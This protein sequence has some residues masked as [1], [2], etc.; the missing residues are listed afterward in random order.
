L[1][2][3]IGKLTALAAEKRA[4]TGR[5]SD[6]GGL[7]LNVSSA[8]TKSWIF[9]WAK[10]GKRREMGLGAYPAVT[11]KFAREKAAR[12]RSLVAAGIDPITERNRRQ[13]KTFAECVDL[14]IEAMEP[15]W[16]N[17]KHRYQWRQTLTNY[18][19]AIRS[20]PVASITTQEVLEVLRPIWGTKSETASRLRGRIE[21]VLDFA[22][23]K[24][25][26]DGE[27]PARWRGHLKNIL[28]QRK[29]LSRGHLAAMDYREVRSFVVRLR[30]TEA[31]AAR[32]LE[33]AI[34][35]AGRTS[36]VLN[37]TWQEIDLNQKIWTI[38]KERMKVGEEHTVPLSGAAM[39]ILRRLYKVRVSNFVFPSQR[40]D[41]PMSNM[42]MTMLLRRMQVD[43][44][45]VHGF[46]SSFRDWCG[47]V[48]PFPRELAEAALAH[49]VGDAVERAYRR[50]K[51]IEKRRKLMEAWA[52]FCGPSKSA[53]VP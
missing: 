51:A 43:N 11:L 38:P 15:N 48:S 5:H 27:N 19:L 52:A 13:E 41:G 25:W 7:Y 4:R 16:R 26:R 44:T 35:T 49:R 2:R 53:K 37:A 28:P 45:T 1:A 12:C 36:E 17:E 29:K 6:G 8:G 33:F 3:T 22:K 40:H 9:M 46:R 30:N 31:M 50:S 20:K 14:Y 39:K 21:L 42:V 32:A 23:A 47:D 18:C 10:Q 34:L 24:D